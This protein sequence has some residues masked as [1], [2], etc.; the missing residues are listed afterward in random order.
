MSTFIPIIGIIVVLFIILSV[1]RWLAKWS[2]LPEDNKKVYTTVT[3][4]STA[5]DTRIE[6]RPKSAEEYKEQLE[7]LNKVAISEVILAYDE[8]LKQARRVNEGYIVVREEYSQ[9]GGVKSYYKGSQFN[10]EKVEV[11][12]RDMFKLTFWFQVRKG[13]K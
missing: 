7:T 10:I 2:K 12:G 9:T 3:Y 6:P 5:F 4:S 1:F 8:T 11:D 13:V